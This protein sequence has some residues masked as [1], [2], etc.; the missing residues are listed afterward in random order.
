[1]SSLPRPAPSGSSLPYLAAY[2]D[3]LRAQAARLLADGRLG[4]VLRQR[5]VLIF[6]NIS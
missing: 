5:G 2:P 1:M 6:R 3:T 4:G